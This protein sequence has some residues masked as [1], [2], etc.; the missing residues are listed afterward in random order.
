MNDWFPDERN[1][2]IDLVPDGDQSGAG[3]ENWGWDKADP[4]IPETPTERFEDFKADM[5]DLGKTLALLGVA[6]LIL[7]WATK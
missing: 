2:V 5:G 4:Y 3:W 7:W 1:Q 6:G